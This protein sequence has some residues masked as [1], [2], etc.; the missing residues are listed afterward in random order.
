MTERAWA[1]PLHTQAAKP[2]ARGGVAAVVL[3]SQNAAP[4]FR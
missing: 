2:K 4:R 3:T 1:R